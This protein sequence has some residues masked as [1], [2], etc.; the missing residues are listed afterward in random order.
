PPTIPT[1]DD[2]VA[3]FKTDNHEASGGA[4]SYKGTGESLL[5]EITGA[6]VKEAL[7]AAEVKAKAAI[8]KFVSEK[9]SSGSIGLEGKLNAL[10]DSEKAKAKIA[11]LPSPPPPPTIPTA[12]DL[13]ASFKT[14][15]HEASGGAIS[16]KGTG[17]SL[18][19]E[20]SGATTQE[21]LNAAEAKAKDAIT[22]FVSEKDS[23]GSIGLEGKLNALV[24]SEK[25]KAKIAS[26]SPLA[27][28]DASV[29][30]KSFPITADD[31]TS[32]VVT[33]M[34]VDGYSTHEDLPTTSPNPPHKTLK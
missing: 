9:D 3:S 27:A 31:T 12:D 32:V 16:Y 2:L 1:A 22:K 23:S 34:P 28:L 13:V 29:L 18:L 17:D 7:D 19:S 14:D 4:I 20:I 24:D 15:N 6:T 21:A 30:E 25:A 5:S 8:V 26:T 33:A 10:V 11:P